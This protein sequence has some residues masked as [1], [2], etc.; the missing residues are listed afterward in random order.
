MQKRYIIALDE[1]TTSARALVYD[2]YKNEIVKIVNKPLKSIFP[3]PG[4]VEQNLNEIFA[5]QSSALSEAVILSGIK[6]DEI[7][8]IG[9]TNQRETVALWDSKTGEAC[10][11][12]VVWQC[13]RTAKICEKLQKKGYGTLIRE[14]TGLKI[15]AYFSASKIRW[16]LDNSDKA[17][18]VLK[19]GTLKAGTID[20]Y[21]IWRLTGNHYTDVTNASRTMLLNIKTLEWDKELL[22]LFDIPCD[23]LP[24]VLDCDSV[25]GETLFLGKPVLLSGVLGD[26]QAALFGQGCVN[27]GEGKNTYGTGCFMLMNTGD[28]IVYSDNGLLATVAW[29]AFGNT[30]YALEGSV[31][32]AGSSVSWLKNN[33]NLIKKSSDTQELAE[34]VKDTG[35][36]YLVP[37]FTGLGAP[38]WDMEVK[39]AISGITL[40]TT[41][42]HI[43]RA[44]LESIAYSSKDV[45][46]CM[47]KDSNISLSELKVDG[48]A[49]TNDFLMQFQSDIL[50]IPL[51]RPK[52]I[53]STAMGAIYMSGLKSGAFSGLN[54]IIARIEY[55]KEFKPVMDENMRQEKYR[56]WIKAV[57]N[58]LVKKI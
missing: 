24:K 37:A 38:Y 23:I 19:K 14:K 50:N 28:N 31:F 17:Q 36:V 21:L 48:G 6:P 5:A 4:W 1:G 35:G 54:D 15:D 34:S 25:F 47:E 41:K 20:S 29:R 32:N 51:L 16:M 33:L 44:V 39:G 46:N 8:S 43:V 18:E 40:S 27:I 30:K 57:K 7:F 52:C 10:C 9:I 12:A 13:R 11:N 58:A 22:K 49:S 42:A 2:V 45:F 56:G 55:D 3:N 26:Q 53:E